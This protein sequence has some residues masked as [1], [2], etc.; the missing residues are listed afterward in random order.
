VNKPDFIKN[1][2]DYSQKEGFSFLAQ[3]GQFDNAEKP[4]LGTQFK[5]NMVI[6]AT[7]GVVGGLLGMKTFIFA[8]SLDSGQL[9]PTELNALIADLQKL[10]GACDFVGIKLSRGPVLLRLGIDA[11]NIS[12]ETLIE[13][14]AV[15]H[16]RAHDFLK[17]AA[18]I[19]YDTKYGVATQVV[20]VFSLHKRAKAFAEGS[21]NRC[22]HK[23]IWKKVYTRPWVVDLEDEDIT[24]LG[25]GLSNLWGRETKKL[26]SE[27]FRK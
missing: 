12:D 13:R 14:C 22:Q 5:Q 9:S 10:G 19:M 11:D 23:T 20:T 7:T 24:R 26:K 1:F 17:F 27:L 2:L 25:Y 16:E 8:G 3:D 6:A 21:A 18:P 15:I 4:S